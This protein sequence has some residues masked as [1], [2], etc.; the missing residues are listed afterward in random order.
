MARNSFEVKICACPGRDRTTDEKKLLKHESV[1]VAASRAR[2][3]QKPAKIQQQHTETKAKVTTNGTSV[4]EKTSRIFIKNLNISII[5][6]LIIR[7]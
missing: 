1:S 7:I 3:N 2:T 6:Y 4:D 5:F